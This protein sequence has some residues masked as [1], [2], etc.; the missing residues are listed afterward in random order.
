MTEATLSFNM[1]ATAVSIEHNN[2]TITVPHS[3]KTRQG[4]NYYWSG[5]KSLVEVYEDLFSDDVDEYNSRQKRKDRRIENYL[6]EISDA[7]EE[8]KRELRRLRSEGATLKT[9]RQHKKAVKPCYEFIIA[10]GN[11]HDNPEFRATDGKRR[12]E[13]RDILKEY[14]NDFAKRYNGKAYGIEMFNASI[15]LCEN[16]QVHLHCDII[17]HSNYNSRGLT[18]RVAMN[19][20]L[21]QLGFEGTKTELPI[22]QWENHE[23]EILKALCL[24]HD[25]E[26]IDGKGSK[27]HLEKEEYILER[28]KDGFVEYLQESQDGNAYLILRENDGFREQ[29]KLE[30][31]R[32]SKLWEAYKSDNAEYWNNYKNYKE[33]LKKEI[34]SAKANKE[35]DKERLN[36]M[37]NSIIYSNGFILFRLFR[38]ISALLLKFKIERE[39]Q[40]LQELQK[41]NKQLKASA[42]VVCE[43]SKITA[44]SLKS[45]DFEMIY[46]SIKMWEN[47]LNTVN[48]NVE[49]LLN[50][51]VFELTNEER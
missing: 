5:N 31:E 29:E 18:H 46:T 48:R 11:M 40:Q 8:E 28:E 23:R 41:I 24:E 35:A 15:H 2:R 47:T 27:R 26:I 1:T 33:A 38:L 49:N 20:A 19:K 43:A 17:F 37:L 3:D 13:A 14:I 12:F 25:I 42:K 10:I 34:L 7:F 39:E 4:D 22:T 44:E 21:N 45:K 16:G 30:Q 32:L 51:T 6:A 50:D 36:R 9:L